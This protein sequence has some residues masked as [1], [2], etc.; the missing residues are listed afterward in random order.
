MEW[1]TTEPAMRARRTG[2]ACDCSTRRWTQS[3]ILRVLLQPHLRPTASKTRR[4]GAPADPFETS[5]DRCCVSPPSMSMALSSTARPNITGRRWDAAFERPTA[6]TTAGPARATPPSPLCRASPLPVGHGPL[7]PPTTPTR[8]RTP[9]SEALQGQLRRP[10]ATPTALRLSPP[11][12]VA[13]LGPRHAEKPRITRSSPSGTGQIPAARAAPISSNSNDL[14][15][16]I[17]SRMQVADDQ[18]PSKPP[19]SHDRGLPVGDRRRETPRSHPRRHHLPE[20]RTWPA[21]ARHGPRSAYLLGLPRPRTLLT[22]SGPAADIP[23]QLLT[24]CPRRCT[25]LCPHPMSA[26]SGSETGLD[27]TSRICLEREADL[28]SIHSGRRAA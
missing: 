2:R 7:P 15:R 19:P 4:D 5:S 17:S 12:R 21:A 14:H 6:W 13:Q 10:P 24:H 22:A 1:R 26:G 25:A 11:S 3:N 8:N 16:R 27:R 9:S 23:A 20:H 18:P 28:P